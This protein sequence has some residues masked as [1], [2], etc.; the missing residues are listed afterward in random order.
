MD[1]TEEVALDSMFP[2]LPHPQPDDDDSGTWLQIITHILSKTNGKAALDSQRQILSK[3]KG[4]VR[5]K[6]RKGSVNGFKD[7]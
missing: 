1:E 6:S 7:R 4:T 5:D 3:V 2:Q